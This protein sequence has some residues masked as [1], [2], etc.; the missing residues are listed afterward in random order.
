M[1]EKAKLLGFDFHH[2]G[3]VVESLEESSLQ[4][5]LLFGKNNISDIFYIASQKVN[6]CFVKIGNG[7]YLELVE[8]V[9]EDSIT[10]KLLQKRVTYYHI[11]YK[12]ADIDS[13]V[14]KLEQLNYKPL[15]CFYSEAFQGKK[16]VFLFSPEAH[17]MELIE[18]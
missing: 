12:V 3:L 5:S 7:A 13:A 4:Y 9:G 11:G 10:K 14:L 1:E 18:R 17:L 16:C 15:E 2:V 8:P 6:V